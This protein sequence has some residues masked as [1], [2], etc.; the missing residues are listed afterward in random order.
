M[1]KIFAFSLVELLISLIVISCI[2]AA[3]AP[4]ITKRVSLNTYSKNTESSSGEITSDCDKF[5]EKCKL[6][7]ENSCLICELKCNSDEYKDEKNCT[8]KKCI[9][10]YGENCTVCNEN[11]CTSCPEGQ[12]FDSS[13]ETCK[14]CS[15]KF[16]NCE[17]CSE[18]ECSS[19]SVGLVLENPNSLN[20]C[21][22]FLCG[23]DDFIQ[24]GSLCI[25]KRNMGDGPSLVIPNEINIVPTGTTCVPSESNPCCWQ[26][27]TS[28]TSCSVA[29][30]PYSG[31][32]R[33][34]CDWWAADY[35]CKNFK[36]GGYTWRLP[37]KEEM[38]DW[39]TESLY[40]GA[41]GLQMCTS[42]S[43]EP[44]AQC[45]GS[46]VCPRTSG[47]LCYTFQIWSST[48]SS[49]SN[50]YYYY[51]SYNW[52]V[53]KERTPSTP[54]SIRCVAE[55]PSCAEKVSEGCLKCSG[56]TCLECDEGYILENGKCTSCEDAFE[57]GCKECTA[58]ECTKMNIEQC[59]EKFGNGCK[60]CRGK[61]CTS[62]YDGY[63][64]MVP[65][66]NKPGG[67]IIEYA[68]PGY[69]AECLTT[70]S[71]RCVEDPYWGLI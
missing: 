48:I 56:K 25:T 7:N 28:G 16:T 67:Y 62:C 52:L 13:D 40:E 49:T 8:C 45:S 39:A 19:C 61:G 5:N 60:S 44:W 34:V 20:P 42:Y 12:Y 17:S 30:G 63:E 69:D 32:N 27:A 68:H 53:D 22:E 4:L 65:F 15:N 3:F 9:E 64:L 51:L 6:C 31:C 1:K 38:K 43:D 58:T 70:F 14:N 10:E 18:N 21:T 50:P 55:V 33:T 23:G 41:N 46:S 24:I 47:S 66:Y 11:R 37:T 71:C 35:I 2:T 36:I 59:K 29:N 57:V 54:A 26:G